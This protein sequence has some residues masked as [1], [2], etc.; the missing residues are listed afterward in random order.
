MAS[1]GPGGS[2]ISSSP[3]TATTPRALAALRKRARTCDGEAGE[4]SEALPSTPAKW[5]RRLRRSLFPVRGKRAQVPTP[6]GHLWLLAEPCDGYPIG[7]PIT[8]SAG[9]VCIGRRALDRIGGKECVLELVPDETVGEY[10]A[11]RRRTLLTFAE[12]A[13]AA[14]DSALEVAPANLALEAASG[15]ESS[16]SEGGDDLS[17]CLERLRWSDE[18]EELPG[19][20][21]TAAGDLRRP[22]EPPT[23][24]ADP[25]AAFRCLQDQPGP[26][27]ADTALVACRHEGALVPY[28]RS[29]RRTAASMP[30]LTGEV[31][32]SLPPPLPPPAS[33]SAL[34]SL[35]ALMEAARAAQAART[36]QRSAQD[37]GR[38]SASPGWLHPTRRY[39]VEAWA[40]QDSESGGDGPPRQGELGFKR[41]A[42]RA[43]EFLKSSGFEHERAEDLDSSLQPY[44]L[45]VAF[46]LHP[47]SPLTRLLVAHATGSGKTRTVLATADAFFHSGKA[48]CLFF[49]EEAVKNNFYQEL[50]KFP[51]AWRDFFCAS[52]GVPGWRERRFRCWSDEEVA[53]FPPSQV[54]ACLGLER[55]VRLGEVCAAFLEEWSREHPDI[56]AP[57]A[58]LRAFKYTTAGGSRGGWRRDGTF[59][60]SRMDSVFRFGYDGQNPM[61]N[62]NLVFDEVHNM[63]ALPRWRGSYWR[64]PLRRLRRTVR[65]CYG[66]TLIFL[67]GSPVQT[68]SQDAHRLLRVL[69]GVEHADAGQEGW[70]DVHLERSPQHFPEVLPEGVP[71]RPLV[72][73]RRNE[74]VQ[75]VELPQ[76][77]DAK[78]REVETQG[79]DEARLRDCCNLAVHHSW[80]LRPQKR[81]LIL[82]AADQHAAKL[83][84]VAQAIWASR[85][86][87]LAAVSRRGGLQV[88]KELLRMH[89]PGSADGVTWIAVFSGSRSALVPASADGEEVPMVPAEVLRRFNDPKQDQVRVLLLDTAFGREGL[90]AFGVERLHLVDVPCSWAE[91]KQTV[92]RAIR[93]G[94]V[95]PQGQR[96]LR[97]HLWAARLADGRTSVDEELV[98]RLGEQGTLLCEAEQEL[99]AMALNVA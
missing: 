10:A 20:A 50:L 9:A 62:K 24:P 17:E 13:G 68:E 66:S 60:A 52:E 48:T 76:E 8:P 47:L 44:Q 41:Y 19:G 55:K 4:V 1:L 6:L 63:L 95:P 94:D 49:P 59:D 75:E 51:G 88:L 38:A 18:E 14:Q 7:C 82:E 98:E 96:R 85:E 73:A 33:L 46:L 16:A 43:L 12:T 77:M 28:G 58:P 93:F 89:G 97:V 35:S 71:D 83:H 15:C 64:E 86:K 42:Q 67:T 36:A 92:G 70:V 53:A 72:E 27:G 37:R 65:D 84:H 30:P 26:S 56:P 78:Y 22:L 11:A 23:A 57:L 54:E 39:P 2:D 87:A 61:S 21:R 69:K 99:A 5:R 80:A 29:R 74:L 25:L 81:S 3:A 34:P 45:R 90:S 31:L 40:W 32:P 79:G 91:Y